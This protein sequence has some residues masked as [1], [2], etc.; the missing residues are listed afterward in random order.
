MPRCSTVRITGAKCLMTAE[1]CSV[2]PRHCG[3]IN[4]TLRWYICQVLFGLRS[5]FFAVLLAVL[6]ALDTVEDNVQAQDD[7]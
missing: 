5:N 7:Q 2:A 3:R 1:W 4:I 6:V